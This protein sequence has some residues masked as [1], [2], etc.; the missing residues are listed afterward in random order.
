MAHGGK[1]KGKA[2]DTCF[3]KGNRTMEFHISAPRLLS[4]PCIS[5][6]T[7]W[8]DSDFTLCQFLFHL[9]LA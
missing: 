6:R 1:G 4:D 2:A 8:A 3:D 9:A 5:E 7:D